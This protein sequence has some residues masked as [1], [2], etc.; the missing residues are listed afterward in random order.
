MAAARSMSTRAGRQA[1]RCLPKLG[2]G[3]GA[4]SPV[5]IRR[6]PDSVS[7]L[8][9]SMTASRVPHRDGRQDNATR[10]CQDRDY[11]DAVRHDVVQFA[12]DPQTLRHCGLRG[13][14]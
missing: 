11:S 1:K 12:G 8:L 5:T 14:Q 4:P 7:P 3:L 13:S 9:A 6:S 2:S 10:A